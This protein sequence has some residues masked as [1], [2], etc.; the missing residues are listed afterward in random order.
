VAFVRRLLLRHPL[1]AALFL[2]HAG[3]IPDVAVLDGLQY[4]P[5]QCLLLFPIS[6]VVGGLLNGQCVCGMDVPVAH[7]LDGGSC[8]SEP[9]QV[10]TAASSR[11]LLVV[12][13]VR[14]PMQRCNMPLTDLLCAKPEFQVCCANDS[15]AVPGDHVL[16]IGH[17]YLYQG[18]HHGCR[19]EAVD[20]LFIWLLLLYG[21]QQPC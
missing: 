7:V 5:Q 20:A 4:L 12:E 10:R 2:Q 9:C 19:D 3:Y 11:G 15:F 14:Q 6:T 8:E 18:E 13:R 21:F 1:P 17:A 16:D